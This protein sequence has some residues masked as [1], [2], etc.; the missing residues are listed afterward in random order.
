MY[1]N[2]LGQK[3]YRH[4]TAQDMADIIGVSRKTYEQKI[5]SGRFTPEECRKFMN[6]FNKSFEFLFAPDEDLPALES[7]PPTKTA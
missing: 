6:A 1:P 2:L 7:D 5:Q 3:A 4:L